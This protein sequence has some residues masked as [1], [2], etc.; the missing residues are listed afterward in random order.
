MPA[1]QLAVG[2]ALMTGAGIAKDSVAA[3]NWY[4]KAA[5]QDHEVARQR[6]AALGG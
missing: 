3:R 6:L 5:A 2:D 1:A 4:E